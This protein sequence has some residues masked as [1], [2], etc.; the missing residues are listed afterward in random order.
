MHHRMPSDTPGLSPL[1]A[2]TSPQLWTVWTQA[3]IFT[4]W[5]F[6]GKGPWFKP[7]VLKLSV[8]QNHLEG[9]SKQTGGPTPEFLTV[10]LGWDPRI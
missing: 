7:E 2:R 3:T 5:L 6:V 9:L 1:E 10:G 8:P 4:I